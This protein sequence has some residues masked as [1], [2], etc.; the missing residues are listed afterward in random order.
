MNMVLSALAWYKEYA[1]CFKLLNPNIPY[2]FIFDWNISQDNIVHR[3]AL[4]YQM[5]KRV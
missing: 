2:A 3:L 4:F 1:K 5:W